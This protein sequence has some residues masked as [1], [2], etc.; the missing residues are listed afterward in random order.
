MADAK[1]VM[2]LRNMTGAGVV[3]A[4]NALDEAGGDMDKAVDIIKKKGG[5]KAAKKS[6]RTTAEGVIASYIH[7]TKKLGAMV[8]VQCETDFVARNEAFVQLANDIAMQ[9][10]AID[11]LYLSPET[12]PLNELEKQ[13]EIFKAEM[14]EEKKP[15]EIKAKIIDGKMNKWYSEVCLT[16]QPFFKNEDVTIEG[17]VNENIAKIGEKIVIA[18]FARYQMSPPTQA[19]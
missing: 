9:V 4:K 15:D 13:Q 16:K 14:A 5:A 12:I 1:Q 8:E 11:P 18:R 10:A 17:L 19:C 6:D 7:H 2:E 3:D